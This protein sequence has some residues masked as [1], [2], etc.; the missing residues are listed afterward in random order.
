[1]CVQYLHINYCFSFLPIFPPSITSSGVTLQDH[2]RHFCGQWIHTSTGKYAPSVHRTTVLWQHPQQCTSDCLI[3]TSKELSVKGQ[4]L[5]E[6]HSCS[7]QQRRQR[8]F[9][10]FTIPLDQGWLWDVN[11]VPRLYL[12]GN[13][14]LQPLVQQPLQ[15]PTIVY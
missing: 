4:K 2:F 5:P 3:P 1:M 15:T 14:L 12:L 6:F 9:S 7:R 13:K 10:P 11:A 8:H